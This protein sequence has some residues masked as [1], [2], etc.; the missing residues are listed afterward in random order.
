MNVFI[1]KVINA[2]KYGISRTEKRDNE[3]KLPLGHLD[4]KAGGI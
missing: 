4:Q 3:E 1:R 2:E